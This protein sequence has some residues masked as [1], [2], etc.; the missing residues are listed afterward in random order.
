VGALA[1][2]HVKGKVSNEESEPTDAD[3]VGPYKQSKREGELIARKLASEGHPIV[4]VCPSTPVG[5]M[6]I[7]PTP[8]GRI[9]VD[10]LRGKMPAYLDTGLNWIDVRDCAEGH[11]LAAERGSPGERYILGHRNMTL[12]EVLQIVAQVGGVKSPRFRIPYG[13]AYTYAL[14]DTFVADHV[15]KRPPAASVTAV[16]LA[17]HY[18]YFDAS[19]AVRNL[20]LPQ[21]PIENALADAVSWFREHGYV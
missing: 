7:K 17:A 12:K 16:R 20:G 10:C 5:P 14:L 8:T 11:L 9:I 19:R 21:S 6:D 1:Y 2:P 15:T 4:I 3:L 18:M 13:V